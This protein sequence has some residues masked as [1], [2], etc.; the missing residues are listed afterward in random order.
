M[1]STIEDW[2]N[3]WYGV[4]LGLAKEEIEDLIKSLQF[5]CNNTG[6]HFHLTSEYKGSGGLGEVTFYV[7]SNEEEDDMLIG[8]RAYAPGEIVNWQKEP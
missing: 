4:E 1:H 7:K 5:L 2:K 6:Q 8:S 3:G